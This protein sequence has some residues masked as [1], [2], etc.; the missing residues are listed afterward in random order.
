MNLLF[1]LLTLIVVITFLTLPLG[2]SI[3]YV[4]VILWII[5]LLYLIFYTSDEVSSAI[6]S[7]ST[8]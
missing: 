5:F 2:A 1:V 7:T 3:G 8:E 4:A 6:D